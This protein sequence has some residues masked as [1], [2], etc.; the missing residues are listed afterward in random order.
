MRMVVFPVIQSQ[1]N[2]KAFHCCEQMETVSFLLASGWFVL[3]KRPR[4]DPT[5]SFGLGGDL[6]GKMSPSEF[7]NPCSF[8]SVNSVRNS[9]SFVKY[10]IMSPK[11]FSLLG[12]FG[13]APAVYSVTTPYG[14]VI[15]RLII[16]HLVILTVRST[17]RREKRS[18]SFSNTLSYTYLSLV[19]RDWELVLLDLSNEVGGWFVNWR[20]G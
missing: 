10:S 18:P 3:T 5:E 13:L 12:T 1:A 4:R 2:Q 7:T 17:Q 8:P 6:L 16:L 14:V 19:H 20:V 15:A 11:F 9:I